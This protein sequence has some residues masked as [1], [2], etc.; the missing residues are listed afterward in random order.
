MAWRFKI[1]NERIEFGYALHRN[2]WKQYKS[3]SIFIVTDNLIGNFFEVAIGVD[4]G[5]NVY[6]YLKDILLGSLDG[7]KK[8][9]TSHIP[10][11]GRPLC[12]MQFADGIDLMTEEN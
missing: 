11:N 10:I 4:Q 1:Y 7:Y 12:S 8:K 5:C 2:K 6:K 3:T 9:K